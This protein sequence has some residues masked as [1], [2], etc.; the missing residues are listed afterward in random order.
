MF[1]DKRELSKAIGKDETF[2]G[3]LLN[4]LN[5]DK[6]IV[7]D[8]LKNKTTNDVRMLRA[9]RR[10]EPVN[11]VGYSEKQWEIYQRFLNE[12]LSRE[13]VLSLTR[14]ATDG[15]KLPPLGVASRYVLSTKASGL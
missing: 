12:N 10:V 1:E 4:T 6:R 8:L 13:E 7:D 2:V 9:I 5:M 14:T 11:Q 3:D 15:K